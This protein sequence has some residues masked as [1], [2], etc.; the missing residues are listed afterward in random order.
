MNKIVKAKPVNLTVP[1]GFLPH[2]ALAKYGAAYVTHEVNVSSTTSALIALRK[3]RVMVDACIKGLDTIASTQPDAGIGAMR[4]LAIKARNACDGLLV[5]VDTK[6]EGKLETTQ[7]SACT[8]A[9]TLA[10]TTI[11]AASAL[12]RALAPTPKVKAYLS[13]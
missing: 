3:A 7:L 4:D 9:L 6:Q 5:R 12:I 10:S 1:E 2:N 8:G 13:A 11:A